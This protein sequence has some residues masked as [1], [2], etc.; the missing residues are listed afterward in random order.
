MAGC[1]YLPETHRGH[2]HTH[3]RKRVLQTRKAWATT[4]VSRLKRRNCKQSRRRMARSPVSVSARAPP[5]CHIAG[6]TENRSKPRKPHPHQHSRHTPG[7]LVDEERI[8]KE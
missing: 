5:S 8:K 6:S 3:A 1:R 7:A 4:D 2:S